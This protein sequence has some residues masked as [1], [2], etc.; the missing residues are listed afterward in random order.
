MSSQV[1]AAAPTHDERPSQWGALVVGGGAAGL[2]AAAMLEGRGVRTLV[3]ERSDR[4][5]NSWRTRY[6]RL[7]LNTART[8]S[9]LPGY[10][11]ERRCG[12]WVSRDDFVSYLER[13]RERHGLRVRHGVTVDRI[14]RDGES[15]QVTTSAG[16]FTAP[17]VVVATGY[18]N[19][20][21][22]PRWE[23]E[24]TFEGRILH[25][26]EYR[27]AEPFRSVDALVVGMGSSGNEIAVDLLEGGARS[28][29]VAMRT[30]PNI[31]PREVLGVPITFVA[32]P[33]KLLPRRVSDA[34]GRVLQR[35]IWGDLARLGIPRAPYGIAS[36]LRLNGVETVVDGGLIAAVRRGDIDILPA[37]TGFEGGD[38][39]FADGRRRRVDLVVAATGFE[40]N[41]GGLVGHLGVLAEDGRPLAVAGNSHSRA[42]GLHFIG[43]V[44]PVSGQLPEFGRTARRI[45][46]EAAGRQRASSSTPRFRRARTPSPSLSGSWQ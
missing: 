43:F 34:T 39:V 40:R 10:R 44:S 38:A 17:T 30:P 18:N 42:P 12:R 20:P 29:A 28:V 36:N 25:S 24:S 22:T 5:G 26:S 33:T 13:Y 8:L 37:L 16:H 19:V 11:I 1:P 15:W 7:R 46:R 14:D 32:Q 21:R 6:D 41:L 31:F 2:S 3:L 23:G 45:A 27:N 35:L 4:V 9:G